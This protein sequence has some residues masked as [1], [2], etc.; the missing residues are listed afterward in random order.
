MLRVGDYHVHGVST[1]ETA[2]AA[3]DDHQDDLWF[4]LAQPLLQVTMKV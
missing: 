1:D 3:D 4:A 2:E